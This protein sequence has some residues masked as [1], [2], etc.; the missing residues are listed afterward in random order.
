MKAKIL[1][2]CLVLIIGL[3]A[4][5]SQLTAEKPFNKESRTPMTAGHYSLLFCP[6]M[7]YQQPILPLTGT[8]STA[9]TVSRE[10]GERALNIQYRFGRSL[11]HR[12]PD[13]LQ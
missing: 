12:C 9:V 10:C 3:T 2:A 8:V 4:C 5:T 11:I 1:C 13:N 6:E 7:T